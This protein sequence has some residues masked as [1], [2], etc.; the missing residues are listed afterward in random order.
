MTRLNNRIK[1]DI[2]ENAL[3]KAGIDDKE[4]A[5][6]ERR[7]NWAE[8]VRIQAVGGKDM[9]RKLTALEKRFKKALEG[10]PESV[11]TGSRPFYR[12][13]DIRVNVGGLRYRAYFSGLSHYNYEKRVTKRTPHDHTLEVGDPLIGEF[14]DIENTANGIDEASSKIRA[15]VFGALSKVGTLKRLLETW[16]EAKELLPTDLSPVTSQLPAV[17]TEDLNAMIGLPSEGG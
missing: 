3:K 13:D 15:N 8:A 7:A 6:K 12:D 4:K 17:C 1:Q 10:V 14:N 5:L 16:P 2:V 9:D 11:C